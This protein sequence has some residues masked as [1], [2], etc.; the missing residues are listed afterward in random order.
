MSS[1]AYGFLYNQN[2]PSEEEIVAHC[3]SHG[4]VRGIP[5]VDRSTNSA[6]A[7]IKYGPNVTIDEARTQDW[8]AKALRDSGVSDLQVPR[9]F[10]AFTSEHHGYPIGYI[11]MEFID[12]VD[13]DSNDVELVA[14]AVQTLIGLKAPPASALGHVGGGTRSIVHS[15]FLEWLPNAEYKSDFFYAHIRNVGVC[16]RLKVL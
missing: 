4:F 9:V 10:H 11:A 16:Q 1:S 14:K 12:G 6:I 8:T 5:I 2:L 15:F 7:W 13:C 3:S